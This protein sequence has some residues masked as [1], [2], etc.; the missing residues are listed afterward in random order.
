MTSHN[1]LPLLFLSYWCNKLVF[2]FPLVHI[3]L[4]S[5]LLISAYI[6]MTEVVRYYLA[7]LYSIICIGTF[8]SLNRY[9]I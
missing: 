2:V 9:I 1:Y 5:V 4:L 6:T 8:N 7:I 3:S